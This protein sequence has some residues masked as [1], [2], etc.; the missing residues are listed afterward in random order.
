[1]WSMSLLGVSDFVLSE[2]ATTIRRLGNVFMH[3]TQMIFNRKERI[4]DELR[5]DI[6]D[7]AIHCVCQG[8][9]RNDWFTV[10]LT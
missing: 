4:S 2:S 5:Q 1:M 10:A 7:Q 8:K 3:F 6:L 9:G